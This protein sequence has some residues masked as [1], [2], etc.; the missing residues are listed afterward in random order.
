M[1]VIYESVQRFG[2]LE[3]GLERDRYGNLLCDSVWGCAQSLLYNRALEPGGDYQKRERGCQIKFPAA[4]ILGHAW[5]S[6]IPRWDRKPHATA[7]EAYARL[8]AAL[9]PVLSK[10]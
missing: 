8:D 10:R 1:L 9:R 4:P 5:K 3:A 2:L 7:E 6:P